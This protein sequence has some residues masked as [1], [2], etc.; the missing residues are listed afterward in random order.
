MYVRSCKICIR[1]YLET[2]FS[3][4]P[5][6]M[7]KYEYVS[8][9]DQIQIRQICICICKWN[10]Y[11]IPVLVMAF[12]MTIPIRCLHQ[13]LHILAWTKV[14]TFW[15]SANQQRDPLHIVLRYHYITLQTNDAL[16]DKP[17]DVKE[18]AVLLFGKHSCYKCLAPHAISKHHFDILLLVMS[19][20]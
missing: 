11:L 17:E 4:T 5:N 12:C 2:H 18:K 1:K 20:K 7:D 3:N 14:S 16:F 9:N 8:Y 13:Y 19:P 6:A 15:H 10:T